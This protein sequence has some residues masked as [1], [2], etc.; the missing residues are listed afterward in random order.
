MKKSKTKPK[1]SDIALPEG[2]VLENGTIFVK[3]R[4]EVELS[5]FWSKNK[6]KYS[7]AAEGRHEMF[8]R[9]GEWVFGPSKS[10]VVETATRWKEMGTYC[11]IGI[12]RSMETDVSR[13]II[14]NTP[15]GRDD[16]HWAY[17][18]EETQIPL[19][20]DLDAFCQGLIFD[21]WM[22]EADYGFIKF[23]DRSSIHTD[24]EDWEIYKDEELT[25]AI[26]AQQ[27]LLEQAKIQANQY[28][29]LQNKRSIF[30][31]NSENK[32]GFRSKD[33]YYRISLEARK[34]AYRCVAE[35]AM[36]LAGLQ[37]FLSLEFDEAPHLAKISDKGL[38]MEEI[39][40]MCDP[41]FWMAE[42]SGGRF[43][44]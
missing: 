40:R 29:L 35:Q 6:E 44:P 14:R 12:D 37:H 5:E 19:C 38:S 36:I 16:L 15:D 11:E 43:L 31:I 34:A 22:S 41:E 24:L 23:H 21:Q 4:N 28:H 1:P 27:F 30:G 20:V 13:L 9:H 8:L 33:L 2:T 17:L 32:L 39:E 25:P 3:L 42:F 7:F 26:T 18:P 10:A